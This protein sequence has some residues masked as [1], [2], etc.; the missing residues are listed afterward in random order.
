MKIQRLG[1]RNIV[2]SDDLGV[3][4]LHLHLIIG[5]TY[6]Y[7]IDTGLGSKS[8]DPIKE[9]LKD[10]VNPIVIINT[11]YHWD[12]I[13]GNHCFNDSIIIAHTLCY[14][15]IEE[16]WD[17][18]LEKNHAFIHG[19]VKKKLPTMLIKDSLCFIKDNIYIFYA[20]GH[21]I[22]SIS[23]YDKRDKIINVGD[24]IGDTMDELIPELEMDTEVYLHS[25]LKY[26]EF[27]VEYCVSGHNKILGPE[28]FKKI[29]DMLR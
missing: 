20:P 25:I 10:N 5:D 3:W 22:D 24:N 4:D 26:Q 14:Q 6:N 21:T 9:Y 19:V 11:H 23:V 12:H 16:Y 13:W 18:D 29:E 15:K 28:V 27:D 2:F 1:T 7:I 17:I 8:I